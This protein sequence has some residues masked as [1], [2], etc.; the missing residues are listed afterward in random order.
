MRKKRLQEKSL[1]AQSKAVVC[2]SISFPS[3]LY[4]TLE[5]VARENKVSLAWVARSAAGKYVA[6]KWS[7]FKIENVRQ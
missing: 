4:E 7:L 1:E 3:D 2:A 5:V 6:Y